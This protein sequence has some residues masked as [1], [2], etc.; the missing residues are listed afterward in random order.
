MKATKTYRPK[1]VPDMARVAM[2][3]VIQ[4]RVKGTIAK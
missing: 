4:I 2:E 1:E 3:G